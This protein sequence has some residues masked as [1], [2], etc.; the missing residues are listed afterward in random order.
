MRLFFL[1][2]TDMNY[3]DVVEFSAD[4]SAILLLNSKNITGG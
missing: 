1:G 2:M 3:C 4:F